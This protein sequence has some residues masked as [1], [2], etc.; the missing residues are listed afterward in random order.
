LTGHRLIYLDQAQPLLFSCQ[1][2]LALIR[3]TEYWA[4]FLKSSAKITLLLGQLPGEVIAPLNPL[5]STTPASSKSWIC[6]VCGFSNGPTP[7]CTLCGVKRAEAASSSAPTPSGSSS[8][9]PSPSPQGIACPVCTFLNHPSLSNCEI[10]GSNL[11][12]PLS[13]ASLTLRDKSG[14]SSRSSTPEP[15]IAGQL[16]ANDF[17]RLSFRKGGE[18]QF[19]AALKKA[20]LAKAWDVAPIDL[21]AETNQAAAE[22]SVGISELLSGSIEDR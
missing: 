16:T 22:R 3:Q 1:L 21:V 12:Q 20:L 4:G 5:E 9:S 6:R 17:V 18:K 7:A 14:L 10:C 11:G 8:Q 15:K 19:Y 13:V 2:S